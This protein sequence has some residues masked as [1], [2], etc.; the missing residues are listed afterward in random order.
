MICDMIILLWIRSKLVQNILYLMVVN[1]P[2]EEEIASAMA[3]LPP[4]K[5]ASRHSPS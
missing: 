5:E 1:M 4:Q 3:G 2:S